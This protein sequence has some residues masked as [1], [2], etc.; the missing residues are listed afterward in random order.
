MSLQPAAAARDARQIPVQAFR[1]ILLWPVLLEYTGYAADTDDTPHQ[2]QLDAW[3]KCLS[4]KGW[5]ER[6]LLPPGGP[7]TP[8]RSGNDAT[9]EE[10]VY[11]HPFIRDFYYGDG[12]E[13]PA[14]R[15]LRRLVRD[16]IAYCDLHL[17][18]PHSPPSFR[19]RVPRV[20]LYL[21]KPLVAMLVIEL[22]WDEPVHRAI[23]G[24]ESRV[25]SGR[26]PDLSLADVLRIQR[27]VRQVYPPFFRDAGQA[28]HCPERIAF[29]GE[30]EGLPD[31]V[32]V[33]SNF[34]RARP[35]WAGQTQQGAEPPVAWHWLKLLEPLKPFLRRGESQRTFR[36]I[37]DDRIPSMVYLSVDDPR[38]I[39]PGD[40]DRLVWC[41]DPGRGPY[42]YANEFLAV[43]RARHVYD[44]YWSTDR[45]NDRPDELELTTRYLCSGFH[46]VALGRHGNWF[47]DTLILDHWRRHYLRI[48]MLA[49]FHRAA[50][51]K[52]ADE[53]GEAVKLLKGL[54]PR[55]ELD[56]AAFLSRV[57]ALQMTYLKFLARVWFSEVSNQLQGQELFRWWS[58]MLGNDRLFQEVDVINDEIH[59]VMTNRYNQRL[60]ENAMMWT[61]GGWV[62]A[63]ISALL[64]LAG[65]LKQGS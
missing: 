26:Q 49:H 47:F 8:M 61:V 36:Q 50:L 51:L 39:S 64:A 17:E 5:R 3:I 54:S 63:V 16:D 35:H 19:F 22:V 43:D 25:D 29:R 4:A 9:F 18:S 38:S 7:I 20:E 6:E 59:S 33:E 21:C 30:R 48:G 62:V 53:M 1:Q 14:D 52:F 42:P 37:V 57:Q 23:E 27:R 10:V 13:T 12:A 55:H 11:F 40:M 46:F 2:G 28:G 65:L 15:V 31:Q 58:G 24:K 41:E 34:E 45:D 44:R 60:S 32:V 56:S